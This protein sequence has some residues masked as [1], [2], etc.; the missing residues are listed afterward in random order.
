MRAYCHENQEN[1]TEYLPSIMMAFRMTP[2][3]QTTG[4]S[5]FEILF[6]NLVTWGISQRA[7]TSFDIKF[8]PRSDKIEAGIPNL[9]NISLYNSRT[10]I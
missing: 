10:K 2:G 8:C 4:F 1:W 9:V 3:V 7:D 6:R 5:P